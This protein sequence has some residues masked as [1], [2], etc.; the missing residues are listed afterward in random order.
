LLA[1]WTSPSF[2]HCVFTAAKAF[3]KTVAARFTQAMLAMDGKDERTAE[4]LRSEAA[5][6]WVTGSPDGFETLIEALRA[7]DFKGNGGARN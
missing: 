2:S 3:D 7:E 1:V 6:K 4:I 5:S